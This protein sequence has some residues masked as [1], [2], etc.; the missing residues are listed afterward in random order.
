MLPSW[1]EARRGAIERA[2]PRLT[3]PGTIAPGA[4]VR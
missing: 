2:V 4:A 1:L 3:L